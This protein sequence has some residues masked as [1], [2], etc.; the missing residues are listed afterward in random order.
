MMAAMVIET[1]SRRRPRFSFFFVG[2]DGR[3]SAVAASQIVVSNQKV[4]LLLLNLMP[5]LNPLVRY[6]ESAVDL[7]HAMLE[8]TADKRWAHGIC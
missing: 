3:S 2:Y 7:V 4:G 1:R 5:R 6:L 8:S